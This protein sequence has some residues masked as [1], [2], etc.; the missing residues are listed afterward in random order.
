MSGSTK[1]ILVTGGCGFVASNLVTHLLAKYPD[2]RVIILDVMT[3]ASSTEWFTQDQLMGRD[4]RVSL[5]Y[6]NVCNG[7]L[8]GDL[9]S[10]SDIVIHMAAETHVTR[11]IHDNRLF[12][13]TDVIGTQIVA[14]AV[15]RYR[16]RVERLI[17]FSTS[18]VYGTAET[19]LMNEDHPLNPRS[20]YASAKCGA[21]RLIYSYQKTYDLPATIIRPFNIFGPWQHVEKLLPRLI[22][23]VLLG[24]PM[25]IHGDGLASRDF[26]FVGDVCGAVDMV[27]HAPLDK[28]AGE[29]FNLASGVDRSINDIAHDVREMMNAPDLALKAIGDRPGQVMR[30]TGDASKIRDTL[31]WVPR[32]SWTEGLKTTVDWYSANDPW[33]RARLWARQIPIK[34]LNGKTE[35]H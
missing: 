3:Y 13:E 23:S 19:A 33:W 26:T 28:V 18:E 4:D 29:V 6:G 8:V 25:P 21:D 14:N 32:V 16:D 7:Q 1:T 17:H 15:L 24:E 10:M 30:H 11:S 27:M 5:Y 34:L 9:V 20:P 35:S 2:Y 22:T 31:G 12:F